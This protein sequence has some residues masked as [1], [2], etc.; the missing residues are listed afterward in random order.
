V[1]VASGADVVVENDAAPRNRIATSGAAIALVV[2]ALLGLVWTGETPPETACLQPVEVIAQAGWTSEVR[3]VTPDDSDLFP[4][5]VQAPGAGLRGPARLLFGLRLDVNRADVLALQSLP[6]IGPS[7]AAGIVAARCERGFDGLADLE[8]VHGIGP[9]TVE[10]L[11]DWA[12][13]GASVEGMEIDV[14][15]PAGFGQG[16]FRP[17]QS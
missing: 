15:C 4:S 11:L 6:G 12:S 7:R 8:R 9:R 5:G 13:A 16:V 1:K 14:V 10:R 2:A 17:I 3:C